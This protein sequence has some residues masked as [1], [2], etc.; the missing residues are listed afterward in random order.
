MLL[1]EIKTRSFTSAGKGGYKATEVDEFLNEIYKDYSG[2]VAKYRA[3]KDRLDTCKN[4]IEEYNDKRESIATALINAQAAAEKQLS[5]AKAYAEELIKKAAEEA[6]ENLSLKKTE[7][8]AYYFD[9]THDAIEQAKALEERIEDLEKRYT[10]L[11]QEYIDEANRKASEIIEKAK[12]QAEEIIK[13]ANAE[14][15]SVKE[16]ADEAVASASAKLGEAVSAFEDFKAKIHSAVDTALPNIDS[17]SLNIEIEPQSKAQENTA[18][19]EFVMPHFSFDFAAGNTTAQS[20]D[21][22][23]EEAEETQE[24]E[25]DTAS[26]E[27]S[28]FSSTTT[29]PVI[30]DSGDYVSKIFDDDSVG[31]SSTFTYKSNYDDI[32]SEVVNEDTEDA[33]VTEGE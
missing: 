26:N 8:D 17:I 20:E 23:S 5:E 32:A 3:L 16:A 14:A 1:N 22:A 2:L 18:A 21:T 24:D 19:D 29:K 13:N 12:A 7:A 6:E 33:D 28:S 25:D 30:P 4:I 27:V 15:K 9:R 10:Q 11:S 31:S